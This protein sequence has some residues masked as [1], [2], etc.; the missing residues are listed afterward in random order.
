M[1]PKPGSQSGTSGVP[2]RVATSN[3]DSGGHFGTGSGLAAADSSDPKDPGHTSSAAA[4]SGY[5]EQGSE[6]ARGKNLAIGNQN[7]DEAATINDLVAQPL[8]NNAI[9][10]AG[11]TL[12]PGASPVADIQI[13]LGQSAIVVGSSSVPIATLADSV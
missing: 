11:A 10:I 4:S 5:P 8:S 7:P 12:T 6:N 3:P 1:D 9:S 13:P 2:I